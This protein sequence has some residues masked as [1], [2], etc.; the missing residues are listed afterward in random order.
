MS[1]SILSEGFWC[2][3]NIF[4]NIKKLKNSTNKKVKKLQKLIKEV[5]KKNKQNRK[6]KRCTYMPRSIKCAH[7]KY[8]KVNVH[9]K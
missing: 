6:N 7:R 2:G 8:E 5:Q 4:S 9:K 3:Y 1:G